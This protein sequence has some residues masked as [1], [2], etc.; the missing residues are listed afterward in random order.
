[1]TAWGGVVWGLGVFFVELSQVVWCSMVGDH[2]RIPFPVFEPVDRDP[3]FA[4]GCRRLGFAGAFE[5]GAGDA[6]VSASR[7]HL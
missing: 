2:I 3:R 1:M 5:P 4:W 6:A 7:R